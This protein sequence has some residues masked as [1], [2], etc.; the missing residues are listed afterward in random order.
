MQ[1]T[2]QRLRL[3]IILAASVLVVVLVGFFL[4]GRFQ[5]R[6]VI[7]DL[8]GRLG[9]NVSQTA[10]GFTYS[11]SSQGH[12]L[13]T[14]HAS[15]LLQYKNGH[16]LLHDVAITLYGPP[17]SHREDRIYGA[18]FDYDP[19]QGIATTKG[20][21]EIDIQSPAS[22]S[23]PNDQNTIHVKTS[24]LTFNSK[25]GDAVTDAYTE[26]HLPKGSGNAM[27]ANYNSKTGL[28]ILQQKVFLQTET[29]GGKASI[30]DASHLNF[31]RDSDQAT[32]LNPVLDYG[33][34][35]SSADQA[36]VLFRKDGSAQRVDAEG[37]LRVTAATGAVMVAEQ[38]HMLLDAKS[39]P[40][41]VDVAGGVN[42]TSVTP[43]ENMHG[44]AT[45]GTLTFAPGST[46]GSVLKHAQFREAVSFVDER[47]G[48]PEDAKG[49]V[50]RQLRGS[51]VDV[52][53]APEQGSK[54]SLAQKVLVQ[55]NAAVVLRTIRSNA[56]EEST[57]VSG[58][59]ILAGLQNG[60]ALKTLDGAGH[61]Q[62]VSVGK[63]GA[64]DTT[65]S[66]TF[67]MIFADAAGK[68]GAPAE[69]KKKRATG[70]RSE[71]AERQ[72][73]PAVAAQPAAQIQ[74]ATEDGNV[75]IRQQPVKKPGEATQPEDVLAYASHA[76]YHAANQL[77]QL[78]GNPRLNQG[79]SMQL[80]ADAID[81]HRDSGD[82]EGTGHV[83]AIYQP[84]A[85]EGQPG[86]ASQKNAE[87]SHVV[88]DR[89]SFLRSK[90]QALFYGAGDQPA[91]LWQGGN[92]VWAPVIELLRDQQ[93]LKAYGT[94]TGAGAVVRSDF[95]VSGRQGGGT[96]GVLRV[97]S[98]TLVYSDKSREGDFHGE[99]EAIDGPSR[100]DAED[101]VMMLSAKG[102]AAQ[103]SQLERMVATGR[104]TIEQPGR[105]GE[106]SKLVYTAQSGNYVLTGTPGAPPRMVDRERGTTTGV[107]L[108][109]NNQ[110]GSVEISGGKGSAVTETRVPK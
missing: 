24:A 68:P 20:S 93:V 109:F 60:N 38:G 7:K 67:H 69:Q 26:F 65:R 41:R 110:S 105:K 96:A 15:K 77:L 45:S 57:N 29:Q 11:Q 101:V 40:Q 108:I 42:F 78:R 10:N 9:A 32:L 22:Q 104:V 59:Q 5:Y 39:N 72:A 2:V 23:S 86:A 98:E 4:F 37:H 85:A 21:V 107:A 53:F 6:H 89:A 55:Q 35:K 48:L 99:V 56:P 84:V 82:A 44:V 100:I 52:D 28:L 102:P 90:N 47:T 1:V 76:E 61:T 12:T 46:G 30:L 16:A 19:S 79:S 74:A 33:Q 94:G 81:Y 31:V 106:G 36:I 14:I 58:D 3:W 64:T 88:A 97:K 87:P 34:E 25:T 66:N 91:H 50:T 49:K 51:V 62:I 75:V 18:D 17:D 73:A 43:A 54:K 83:K 71:A 80:A 27:G 92:A 103:Q 8:P 13:F 70:R 63:D 95:A